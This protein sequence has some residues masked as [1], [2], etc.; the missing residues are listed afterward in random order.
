MKESTKFEWSKVSLITVAHFFHDIYT[1]FLAPL[2]PLLRDTMGFSLTFAGFLSVVQRLP[3][4]LN[5]FV[6]M[7]AE[8]TKARYFVIFT[9]AVTAVAM[10]L[11]TVAPNKLTLILL[12]LISGISSSFFHVPSPVMMRKVSGNR[13]GMGMSFYMV[14]GEL[15]RS[16]GPVAALGAVELWGLNG[17]TYFIPTGILASLLLYFRLRNISIAEDVSSSHRLD[18]LKTFK[19]FFPLISSIALILFFRAAMKSALT[20]YLPI[21]LKSRGESLWYA[22][23]AL[24]ILQGAGVLGTF[25]AGTISDKIGRRSTLL[26]ASIGAPTLFFAF[27]YTTGWL[28]ILALIASGLFLFAT[29]P[30]FL[31][32]VNEYKTKHSSFVNAVFMTTTFLIGAIMVMVV[33]LMGDYLTLETTYIVVGAFAFL[34]VP[35]VLRM[36]KK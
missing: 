32:I 9:P 10:S 28:Q 23:I 31:A 13:V 15:A 27:L 17:V 24:S 20:F 2:L 29:G 18:Y 6:G 25:F 16:A 8:R 12:V 11:I 7:L 14:G 19:S 3:T 22:G 4:L 36:S 34:S 5:P 33:G 26:I 30:V 21:F 35:V 1:A